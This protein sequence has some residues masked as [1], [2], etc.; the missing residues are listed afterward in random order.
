ML[1]DPWLHVSSPAI[2]FTLSSLCMSNLPLLLTRIQVIVF[3]AHQDTESSHVKSLN[4]SCKDPLPIRGRK[5]MGTHSGTLA[6][7]IPWMEK[8]GAGYSLW[9]CKESDKTEHLHFHFSNKVVFYRFLANR[10]CYL[11]EKTI[12][13]LLQR[14]AFPRPA[15]LQTPSA[16]SSRILVCLQTSLMSKQLPN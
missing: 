5:G 2:T 12:F 13:S 10:T 11:G 9:G 15:P 1:L 8:P 4:H 16:Y 3:R 14:Q 7:K 6:W